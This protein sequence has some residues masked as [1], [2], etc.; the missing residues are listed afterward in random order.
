MPLGEGINNVEIIYSKAH[1]EKD[2]DRF[3]GC[4]MMMLFGGNSDGR[5][6]L[7]GNDQY[8]NY[9]FHSE[10]ADGIPSAEYFPIN[11]FTIIGNSKITCIAQ[12]YN[13]QLIFTENEAFYSVCE[14]KDDG[15]G[16]IFSS[17][18]V[19]SLNGS[20][21][22]LNEMHGCIIDNRPITLC[23]DGLNAWESTSVE[24]EKNAICISS[25]IKD[26]VNRAMTSENKKHLLDFQA[27][28]ELFFIDGAVVYIYNYGNGAWYKYD[29]FA[30]ENYKA[31]GETL[32][33][34]QGNAI[35]AF[36]NKKERAKYY[37]EVTSPYLDLNYENGKFDVSQMEIFLSVSG[38]VSLYVK[39]L[40]EED[41]AIMERLYD[42]NFQGEK[43]FRMSL[44]PTIRRKTPL[45]FVISSGGEGDCRI[46][47]IT[48][49]TRERK[50]S[51]RY[52]GLQ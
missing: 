21:G 34:T 6:F 27:N 26:S 51:N 44:R 38:S 25:P 2:K 52:N 15:L 13:R 24:N 4:D 8:P 16:N 23:H 3:F 30:G 45:K 41:E 20:K 9:R 12:Q 19:Y 33:F 37:M 39:F 35:F 42:F 22:C 48:L 36:D 46:H 28:R 10:L 29:G 18:P 43:Y 7:W 5:I 14:L 31:I 49:K 17:F 32:Y 11:A 50:K 40:G 1:T 47:S